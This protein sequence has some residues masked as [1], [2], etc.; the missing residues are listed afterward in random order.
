MSQSIVPTEIWSHI[1]QYVPRGEQTKLLGVS[2]LFHDIALDLIFSAVKIYFVGGDQAY[3][4]LN[5][6]HEEFLDETSQKLTTR[7]WEILRRITRD[8]NFARLVKSLTVVAFT[9][10]IA[11]F[12]QLCLGDALVA[13]SNLRTFRWHGTHPGLTDAI[14]GHISQATESICLQTYVPSSEAMQRFTGLRRVA[15]T[16]PFLYP[17]DEEA[18]DSCTFV[19][20][21][22]SA[23]DSTRFNHVLGSM[24]IDFLQSLAIDGACIS[25]MPVRILSA[26]KELTICISTDCENLNLDLVFRHSIKLESFSIVG[27]I[28]LEIFPSFITDTSVLPSLHSFRLS[29]DNATMVE[30][31][32]PQWVEGLFK[33]I[34][35][36]KKLR[37]LYLRIPSIDL[38]LL[39]ETS[40][41]DLLGKLKHL[42][43]L[44]LHTGVTD[45]DMP[46][47]CD[48][49]KILPTGLKAFHLAM[50]WSGDPLLNL[51]DILATCRH[52]TFAHFYG[53]F[54]RLPLLLIDLA[55]DVTSLKMVGL[56]RALWDVDRSGPELELK[57]WPRWKIKF[58]SEE[59]FECEDAY[60]L[61]QFN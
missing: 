36:R 26:L 3:S 16:S 52:L 58:A 1:V 42:Q 5:T 39:H 11:L 57:K 12:E 28:G 46:F 38:N 6:D 37:R 43:V 49:C 21:L 14:A 59:D 22:Y 61:F 31:P 48:L 2:S 8:S 34:G 44:G 30:T 50:D 40:H 29:C 33:F 47:I 13:L 32:E 19:E 7:S 9:D 55:T 10:G 45:I 18:H 60:W 56:N 35:D 53:I 17:D 24:N 27:F 51:V 23:I 4:M 54:N 15:F 25:G 20:E 41:L